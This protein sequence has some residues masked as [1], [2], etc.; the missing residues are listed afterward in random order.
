MTALDGGKA[1]VRITCALGSFNRTFFIRSIPWSGFTKSSVIRRSGCFSRYLSNATSELLM[2]MTSVLGVRKC[3][4]AQLRKSSSG[5]TT[6][7]VFVS[8]LLM[9]ERVFSY[10]EHNLFHMYH[11][12]NDFL[13]HLK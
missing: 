12:T 8:F 9:R 13:K 11:I 2:Q 4:S 5:S 1:V 3:L 7:M 6:M 10:I